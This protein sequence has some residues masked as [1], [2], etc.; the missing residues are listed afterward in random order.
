LKLIENPPNGFLPPFAF[1][2]SPLLVVV[3]PPRPPGRG[4]YYHM[5]EG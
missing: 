5:Y 4:Y 1:A 2:M 3:R